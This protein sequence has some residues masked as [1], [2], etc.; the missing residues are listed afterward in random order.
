M[1]RLGSD[2]DEPHGCMPGTR[3]Q[4]LEILED[5][6]DHDT[7]P[8]VYWLKGMAGTG[9]SSIA[10]S[11]CEVLVKKGKLGGRF[12]C[13]PSD[14]TLRDPK[15][16]VPTIAS[17]LARSSPPIQSELCQVLE[18]HPDV[19]SFNSLPEQFNL[20]LTRTI[21]NAIPK[22]SRRIKLSL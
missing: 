6:A 1:T 21:K 7:T 19:A 17:M 18:Q 4:T 22:K 5:W 8:K 2:D 10:H 14:T 16:I 20:L 12:F 9:K 13:S 11:F 3:E 15:A